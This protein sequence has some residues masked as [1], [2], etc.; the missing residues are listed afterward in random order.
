MK[1]PEQ[2]AKIETTARIASRDYERLAARHR[3][4]NDIASRNQFALE[5]TAK[6]AEFDAC[7]ATLQENA[8]PVDALRC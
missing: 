6:L 8:Y 7:V 2:I 1:T 4:A 5:M 3:T